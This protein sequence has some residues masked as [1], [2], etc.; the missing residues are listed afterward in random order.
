MDYDSTFL[1]QIAGC[2]MHDVGTMQFLGTVNIS[3]IAAL[4]VLEIV[5]DKFDLD[6][7]LR[8]FSSSIKF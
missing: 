4:R 8:D 3:R 6:Q 2:S 5:V 1:L 7:S